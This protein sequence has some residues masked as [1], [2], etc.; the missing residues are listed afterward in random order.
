M[1]NPV[2]SKPDITAGHDFIGLEMFQKLLERS[3]LIFD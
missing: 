1:N 2:A 3:V